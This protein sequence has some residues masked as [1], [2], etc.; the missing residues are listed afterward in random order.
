M[1]DGIERPVRAQ[2]LCIEPGRVPHDIA[3]H[4]PGPDRVE[5]TIMAGHDVII[6]ILAQGR[7]RID[8]PAAA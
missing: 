1:V 7:E 2:R 3:R 6:E 5:R 4:G 8:V